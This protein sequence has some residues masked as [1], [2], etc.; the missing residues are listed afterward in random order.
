MGRLSKLINRTLSFRLTLRVIFA[1]AILLIAALLV[2]FWFSRKAV[3]EE[4]LQ[5]AGQ[6]LE[7]TVE[8][9]DNILLSVEQAAGNVYWKMMPYVDD[10]EKLEKYTRQLRE[11]NPYITGCDIVW[12]TDTTEAIGWTDPK[13]RGEAITS[14]QLP[15]FKGR[16]KVATMVVGVSQALLSKIVLEAKP[17]PHSF[18]TLLRKDGSVIIHPDSTVLNKNLLVLSRDDDQSMRETARSM[19]SGGT[20]YHKVRLDGEDYYAFYKPFERANVPGRDMM[21]LGWSAAVVLPEDDIFGDYIQLHYVVLVIA[22]VG[23]LLLLVSCYLFIHR[24]LL[25]LRLLE[26]SAHRIA[27]GYYNEPIPDSRQQDEVGR[28]QRHFQKMQQSLSTRMAE[29]QQLSDTLKQRGEELQATYE[30]AQAANLMKTN[31]LYNMSDQMM[32]PVGGIFKSVKTISDHPDKLTEE[33]T[34]LL[35]DEIQKQGGKVTALLNQLIKDSEKIID[36]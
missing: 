31:F 35:V 6:T 24:Q 33:E 18:C 5:D 12:N 16:R 7:A 1:L 30:Q 26:R 29:M 9:I 34:S 20:G 27:E 2:M 13:T 25:P 21:K 19:L 28:L 10:P 22:V 36:K 11:T 23:L 32:A 14:Y 8:Q 17:S 4:T 15:L 3:K